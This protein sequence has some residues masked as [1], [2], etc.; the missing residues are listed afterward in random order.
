MQLDVYSPLTA[1]IPAGTQVGTARWIL[2]G[3]VVAEMPVET[4]TGVE[5]DRWKPNALVRWWMGLWGKSWETT[6]PGMGL[7]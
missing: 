6:V 5:D 2:D 1:P 3:E 4:G 7:I